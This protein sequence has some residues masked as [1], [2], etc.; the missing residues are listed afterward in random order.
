MFLEKRCLSKPVAVW[1]RLCPG[2]SRHCIMQERPWPDRVISP[3]LIVLIGPS[4][5]HLY[6]YINMRMEWTLKLLY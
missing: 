6:R 5:S 4:P 2:H 3:S 1:A